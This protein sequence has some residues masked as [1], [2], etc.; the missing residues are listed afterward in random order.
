MKRASAWLA[1]ETRRPPQVNQT[2]DGLANSEGF[3]MTESTSKINPEVDMSDEALRQR[4]ADHAA[5]LAE[6]KARTRPYYTAA[7]VSDAELAAMEQIETLQAALL[8]I[9]TK[10]VGSIADAASVRGQVVNVRKSFSNWREL[11]VAPELLAAEAACARIESALTE[12]DDALFAMIEEQQSRNCDGVPYGAWLELAPETWAML[13]KFAATEPRGTGCTPPHVIQLLLSHVLDRPDAA[14]IARAAFAP[15]FQGANRMTRQEVADAVVAS[16]AGGESVDASDADDDDGDDNEQM[17]IEVQ[18][19]EPMREGG[20][21]GN[22]TMS[23]EILIRAADRK[24]IEVELQKVA[25][26][27]ARRWAESL[28]AAEVDAA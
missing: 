28:P 17:R 23:R 13:F 19:A 11:V 25:G 21:I 10:V 5:L 8:T 27:Y 18:I 24:A 14:E 15:V 16:I 12:T 4:G 2:Y 20:E 1:P 6:A 3:I 9:R 26:R 22:I 7:A